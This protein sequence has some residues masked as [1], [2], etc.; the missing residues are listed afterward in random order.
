MDT[1]SRVPV[2]PEEVVV[3]SPCPWA[4]LPSGHQAQTLGARVTNVEGESTRTRCELQKR[5]RETQQA[6]GLEA[7]AGNPG[8]FPA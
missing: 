8:K 7:A 4:P 5:S 6:H 2:W 1:R 3:V